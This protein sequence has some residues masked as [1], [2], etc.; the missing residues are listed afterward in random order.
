MDPGEFD[1]NEAIHDEWVNE[2]TPRDRVREV[3]ARAY[4]SVSVEDIADV[5]RTSTKAAREH[6]D[7]LASDGFVTVESDGDGEPVYRR[8]PAS[9]VIEQARDILNEISMGELTTRVSQMRDQVDELRTAHGVESLEAAGDREVIDS[10]T[11]NEWERT[12]RN[13]AFA[14]V[15]LSIS[16]AERVIEV[17]R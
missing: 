8:S 13:L 6:L 16:R 5:A 12:R 3:V 17:G 11:V 10:E 7:V 2:T 4:T 9:L 14:N 1:V 15:A